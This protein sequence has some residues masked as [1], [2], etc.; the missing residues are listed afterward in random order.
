M[1]IYIDSSVVKYST[2]NQYA[3][4]LKNEI[5]E[6]PESLAREVERKHF[7]LGVYTQIGKN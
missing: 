1:D 4:F 2:D 3:A 6:F 7:S 5:I